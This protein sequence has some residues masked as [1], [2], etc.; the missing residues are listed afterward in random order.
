MS[1]Q[2]PPE[3]LQEM[4]PDAVVRAIEEQ[5]LAFHLFSRPSSDDGEYHNDPEGTWITSPRP[6]VAANCIVR[7]TWPADLSPQEARLRVEAMLAQFAARQ[8]PC[9]WQVGPLTT[10][11]DLG[12]YLEACGMRLQDTTP[13]Y[14]LDLLTLPAPM[15]NPPPAS[16]PG[17]GVDIAVVRD[18]STHREWMQTLAAGVFAGGEIPEEERERLLAAWQR[19]GVDLPLRLYLARLDGE[20]VATAL[21]FLNGGVVGLY[22]VHT[23]AHAR[24]RGIGAAITRA[25]LGGARALG[26]RVAVLGATEMGLPIYLRLGFQPFATYHTYVSAP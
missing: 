17:P 9:S 5:Q 24:G 20:P 2:M 25:A 16:A 14:A 4:T 26:Y 3:I 11:S 19:M 10:P 6:S 7:T 15:P 23:V 12:R 21:I 1:P 8:V 22:Q 18:A 13:W